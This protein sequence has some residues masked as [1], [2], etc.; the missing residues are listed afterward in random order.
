[1]TALAD[2]SDINNPEVGSPSV[3]ITKMTYD[4]IE[5]VAF[6]ERECYSTPWSPNSFLAMLNF[7]NSVNLVALK[8]G[9]VIG[10]AISGFV[11]DEADLMN[12]AVSKRFR[13]M[14]IGEKLLDRMIEMLS[15]KGI[16]NLFLEVRQSNVAA[17]N[18][19]IKKGF[20]PIS[21][22]K[23]YYSNPT[24]DAIVMKKEL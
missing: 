5:S 18:L 23:N 12:I 10:Y 9:E 2:N 4:H 15:E 19:Y 6:L 17:Q 8:G 13:R 1:M 14:G 24:E 7:E 16:K 20:C 3:E 11:M 22:R 21:T